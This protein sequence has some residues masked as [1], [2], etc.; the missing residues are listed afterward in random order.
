MEEI[1]QLIKDSITD[2]VLVSSE[3]KEI[4]Q[5]IASK[6]FSKREMDFLRSQIF[7]IAKANQELLSKE[8]LINWIENTSKLTLTNNT[9]SKSNSYAY[10]SPGNSCKNAIIQQIKLATESLK[11]CVF[12]I[13]DNEISNEVI[14][15]HKRGIGVKIITDNDKSFDLGSDIEILS[16]AGIST[17]T[18]TTSNHM[19]HKFCVIDK[20]TLITGSYNW[21]RSAAERNQE[22]ILITKEVHIIKDYLREFEKLWHQLENYQ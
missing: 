10:F 14:A 9:S 3:K 11:I 6:G 16:D 13:S 22:N 2:Q 19:H 4:K 7:D 15:A 8:Q 17:K 18:D 20:D 5:L 12:T 21:T 1:I